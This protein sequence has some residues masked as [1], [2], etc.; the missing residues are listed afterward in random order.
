MIFF[1]S[2]GGA[3]GLPIGHNIFMSVF[4]GALAEINLGINATAVSETG[5]ANFGESM[6]S[7]QRPGVLASYNTAVTKTFVQSVVTASVAFLFSLCLEWRSVK[8]SRTQTNPS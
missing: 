5:L 8:G 6:A 3:I 1:H 4:R 2:I 7:G